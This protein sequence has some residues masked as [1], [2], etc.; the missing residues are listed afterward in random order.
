VG[1]SA[2]ARTNLIDPLSHPHVPRCCSFVRLQLQSQSDLSLQ[3]HIDRCRSRSSR[4]LL[5]SRP[6]RLDATAE[7]GAG[8]GAAEELEQEPPLDTATE[9]GVVLETT[10]LQLESG[11]KDSTPVSSSGL[12]LAP[13]S[14]PPRSLPLPLC[15][16]LAGSSSAESAARVSAAACSCC[17]AACSCCAA[18]CSCCAAAARACAVAC[19][20]V[21]SCCS[22]DALSILIF[23]VISNA[24][25]IKMRDN[26]DASRRH[27]HYFGT[28]TATRFFGRFCNS[29]TRFIHGQFTITKPCR[30]IGQ[31]NK[32]RSCNS[33]WTGSQLCRVRAPAV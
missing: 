27:R 19:S 1:A 6:P 11:G 22:K 9:S 20:W 5:A 32:G 2:A 33:R 31:T 16:S 25:C 3:L 26:I 10:E 17:A 18:A 15:T 4:S 29:H 30:Q 24:D 14:L 21:Y 13:G 28:L 7:A 23:V 8:A 12:S